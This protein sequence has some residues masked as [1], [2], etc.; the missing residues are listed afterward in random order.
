MR[1][2]RGPGEAQVSV[3]DD[4][5]GIP[6]DKQPRLF[7]LS[8]RAHAG[9]P[10]DVG[11][12]GVG[13]FLCRESVRRHGGRVWFESVEGRGSTFHVG[14]PLPGAMGRGPANRASSPRAR[15]GGGQA[16]VPAPRAQRGGH[17]GGRAPQSS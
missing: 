2:Q 8:F 11:G 3:H 1:V 7:E 15:P 16:A 4:G 10:N 12:L 17:A 9:T 13:L 14:L 5:F 6:A